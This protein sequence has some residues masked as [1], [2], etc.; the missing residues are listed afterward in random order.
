MR[1]STSLSAH[2]PVNVEVNR[3]TTFSRRGV[4]RQSFTGPDL[5]DVPIYVKKV[6]GDAPDTTDAT[7]GSPN[8]GHQPV[9]V[10]LPGLRPRGGFDG[11]IP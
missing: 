4:E 2:R 11:E 7:A 6:R 9:R 10:L 1:V 3:I 5:P 8:P